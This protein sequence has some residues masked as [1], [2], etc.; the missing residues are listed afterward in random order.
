MTWQ[1]KGNQPEKLS[2]RGHSGLIFDID[3]MCM[4]QISGRN[5][6]AYFTDGALNSVEVSGNAESIYFDTEK[7]NP[8]EAFNQ[9]VSSA[10]RI[11]FD[12]GDIK[13]IVLLQKPEGVWSTVQGEVPEL[14]GMAWQALPKAIREAFEKDRLDFS[15]EN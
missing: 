6:D 4:Q 11:D 12:A 10:M 8:C 2:A 3:S 7:P 15:S 9:S 13:D 5:L 14:K 1:L